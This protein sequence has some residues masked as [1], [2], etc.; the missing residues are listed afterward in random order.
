MRFTDDTSAILR[1]GGQALSYCIPTENYCHSYQ[2]NC[3]LDTLEP[4]YRGLVCL[5]D[6]LDVSQMEP[7]MPTPIGHEDFIA[8]M[9]IGKHELMKK[10][11]E[12]KPRIFCATIAEEITED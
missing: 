12:G 1:Y 3:L 10:L 8:E 5:I 4:Y 6:E 9:Q 2:S 7:N 11:H